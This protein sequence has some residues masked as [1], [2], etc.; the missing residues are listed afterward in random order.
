MSNFIKDTKDIDAKVSIKNTEQIT[1]KPL[2]AAFMPYYVDPKSMKLVVLLKREI[3]P[4]AYTRTNRK[5]GLT[6]LSTQLPED[7]PITIEEAFDNLNIPASLQDTIP[8]GSVMIDPKTSSAATELVLAQ[9]EPVELLDE[10]RGIVYQ[11]KGKYEIGAIEF[12]ALLEAVQENFIQDITTRFML[13]ELYIL[14]VEEANKQGEMDDN[15]MFE[16]GGNAG[17]IV[18][19]ENK[20]SKINFTEHTNQTDNI[21]DDILAENADMNFGAMYKN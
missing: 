21:P 18:G 12:D 17:G 9:I 15:S 7:N 4:G 2:L 6:C 16:K 8:F 11:E 13:S 19:G 20:Y 10:T 5:M 14:A 3:L 1:H